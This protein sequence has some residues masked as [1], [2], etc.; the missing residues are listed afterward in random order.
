[1]KERK[2][3]ETDHK[4]ALEKL[5]IAK[6]IILVADAQI[7][8]D[9]K[10]ITCTINA[11]IGD[12]KIKSKLSNVRVNDNGVRVMKVIYKTNVKSSEMKVFED[13]LL[14]RV[15]INDEIIQE[16]KPKKLKQKAKTK[17]LKSEL[18]LYLSEHVVINGNPGILIKIHKGNSV[19]NKNDIA[20]L[21]VKLPFSIANLIS[22]NI[23]KFAIDIDYF[24]DNEELLF[25]KSGYLMLTESFN[26]KLSQRVIN[27]MITKYFKY[28]N[29]KI[30]SDTSCVECHK[31]E[32][33]KQSYDND[34][35]GY[36]KALHDQLERQN[37]KINMLE[38]NLRNLG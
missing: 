25:T 13:Q 3:I 20:D 6:R 37:E 11:L 2:L 4:L 24:I 17:Q 12:G 16:S 18:P 5:I 23:H 36:M 35:L 29:I 26:D 33:G 30:N 34:I 38:R 27:Q 9:R 28:Q 31:D 8:L 21:H 1:M 22:D 19:I 32:S 10:D 15:F 7:I 14:E